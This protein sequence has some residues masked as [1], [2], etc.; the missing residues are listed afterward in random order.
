MQLFSFLVVV[1]QFFRLL[2]IGVIVRSL[3]GLV[4]TAGS[5]FNTVDHHSGLLF[6]N[7]LG[8]IALT[9]YVRDLLIDVLNLQSH[10]VTAARVEQICIFRCPRKCL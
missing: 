3:L 7:L 4:H 5:L 1:S 2:N 10:R 8:S 6:V 9:H